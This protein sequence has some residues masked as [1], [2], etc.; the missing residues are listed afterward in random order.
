MLN[1]GLHENEE[2]ELIILIN[3]APRTM[4]DAYSIN[5]S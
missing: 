4:S 2:P 5:V 1:C 3:P